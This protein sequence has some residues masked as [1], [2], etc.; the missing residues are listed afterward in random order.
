MTDQEGHVDAY[1]RVVEEVRLIARLPAPSECKAI[2]ERASQS[3]DAIGRAVGLTGTSILGY[4]DGTRKPRGEHLRRYVELL[5]EL[6]E[7][8]GPAAHDAADRVPA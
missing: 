7:L 2:R 6:N 3:R 5:E 4:E 1:D 8:V